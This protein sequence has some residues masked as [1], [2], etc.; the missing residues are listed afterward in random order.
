MRMNITIALFVSGLLSFVCAVESNAALIA[1]EG[2]DYTASQTVSGLNG[3]T[4]WTGAWGSFT[5]GTLDV[6]APGS[7]YPGLESAGNKAFVTPTSDVTTSRRN[8]PSVNSGTVYM[9][10]LVDLTNTGTRFLGMQLFEGSTERG[11]FGTNSGQPNWSM[12]NPSTGQLA[13]SVSTVASDP[14]L[15][16]MR[17]DFNVLG[18]GS[19]FERMRLYVNPT[20]GGTEPVTADADSI[21]TT[22]M[23]IPSLDGIAIGAGFQTSA[24]LTTSIGTFDELRIGTLWADVT[25]LE[26]VVPPVPEPGT[27]T[28]LL[29]G[30]SA[31]GLRRRKRAC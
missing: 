9:S 1:H 28:L 23:S 14:T 6:T 24:T 16:V 21:A 13:S 4:G 5:G 10:M 3:G 26:V 30:A 19:A 18:A 8:F 22:T 27:L 29:F 2:F 25:P 31:L 15:L 11:F 17:L 20:P 12:S 7:T